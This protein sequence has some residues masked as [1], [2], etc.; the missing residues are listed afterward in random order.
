M[1]NKLRWEVQCYGAS[2]EVEG[3]AGSKG[4]GVVKCNHAALTDTQLYAL[5][6]R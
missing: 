1:S 2:R 6:R 5:K 4:S 3:A